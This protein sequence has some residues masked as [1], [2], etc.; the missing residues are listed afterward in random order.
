MTNW[1]HDRRY[2]MKNFIMSVLIMLSMVTGGLA[3]G[4]VES[5]AACKYCGMDRTAFGYSRMVV[6]YSDGSST[7]TC[8][9]NCVVVDMKQA[10]KRT[11]TAFLVGDYSTRKLIDGRKAAW[12]IGGSKSG[13]MTPVAKWAF[14]RKSDADRFIRDNGGRRASFEEALAATEKELA[15][16]G[17]QKDLQKRHGSH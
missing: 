11:A 16:E 12:V 8:S 2:I 9:L 5:P 7:G 4:K 13:V 15:E 6:K 17:R 14:A 10:K 1:T 3:A